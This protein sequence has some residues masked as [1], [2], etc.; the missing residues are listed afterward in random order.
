MARASAGLQVPQVQCRA[1]S[2]PAQDPFHS[3]R[4]CRARLRP[5]AVCES[6]SKPHFRPVGLRM[7][8]TA[9]SIAFFRSPRAPAPYRV[10]VFLRADGI[11]FDHA[12]TS[13][14]CESNREA[15]NALAGRDTAT[16]ARRLVQSPSPRSVE[17]LGLSAAAA[18]PCGR[19]WSLRAPRLALSDSSHG[20]S[21][22]G[23]QGPPTIRSSTRATP[24]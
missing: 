23:L 15:A 18:R 4:R 24:R 10:A 7:H 21:G 12:S 8:A 11:P 20:S 16:T 3:L 5:R 17:C 1:T 19:A 2:L 9:V 14:S 22:H 6:R 13:F